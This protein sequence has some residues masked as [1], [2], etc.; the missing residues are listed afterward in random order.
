MVKEKHKA[1]MQYRVVYI[2]NGSA[3]PS[4]NYYNVFHSSEAL[5]D[6]LHTL[7]KNKFVK[8]ITI[9]SVD[10][11]CPYRNKWIDRMEEALANTDKKHFE[12]NSQNLT[13]NKDA[14]TE[15]FG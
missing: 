9:I 7:S 1:P 15:R 8:Q 2:I 10:E 4:S 6:L 12:L 5:I 14:S 11:F 3:M 13:F